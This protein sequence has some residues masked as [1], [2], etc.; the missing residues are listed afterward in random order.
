MFW[1]MKKEEWIVRN[2]SDDTQSDEM[3]RRSVG[4][5]N[6]GAIG[7]GNDMTEEAEKAKEVG[8]QRRW[9]MKHKHR[10]SMH[11]LKWCMWNSTPY[12]PNQKGRNG[13]RRIESTRKGSVVF[14]E[15]GQMSVSDTSRCEYLRSDEHGFR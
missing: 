15:N 9:R 2:T 3:E 12:E 5:R 6:G 11:L 13:K 14:G 7:K 8:Q 4:G 10:N 1:V